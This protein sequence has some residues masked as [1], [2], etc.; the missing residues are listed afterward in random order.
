MEN[1]H[2]AAA[3]IDAVERLACAETVD[4]ERGAPEKAQAL[5]IPK[6]MQL[7]ATKPILD[8][9]L[10][11]PERKQGEATLFDVDSFI[12]HVNRFKSEH[13]AV[14]F[15]EVNLR[16][17]AVYDYH[18]AGAGHADNLEHR[19]LYQ[20]PNSEEWVAWTSAQKAM[21]QASFAQLIEDRIL[22]ILPPDSATARVKKFADDLG[23]S[24]ASPA[25]MMELSRGIRVHA[26]VRVEKVVNLQSGEGQLNFSES[27]NDKNGA[28]LKI[29]GGF[30][31]LIPVFKNG[32]AYQIPVRL[33]YRLAPAQGQIV[34]TLALYRTE[35]YVRD[36]TQEVCTKVAEATKLPLF[37]GQPEKLAPQR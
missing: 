15:D 14:F 3:I 13:S 18:H 7:V 26:D 2:D 31:L 4:I 1:Q 19:A 16:L 27:H 23:I 28:P 34:W 17:T 10:P 20:F 12:A 8:A 33:R 22:D 11:Y 35:V 30:A 37:N 32:A 6:G 24:L 29:P 36:A 5:L 21:D 9:F 25:K